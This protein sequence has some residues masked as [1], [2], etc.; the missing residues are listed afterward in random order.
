M[1]KIIQSGEKLKQN[2]TTSNMYNFLREKEMIRNKSSIN[3]TVT[4]NQLKQNEGKYQGRDTNPRGIPCCECAN[5]SKP[6]DDDIKH[7]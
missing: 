7:H 6:A 5:K 3:K 4:K 1:N 2:F